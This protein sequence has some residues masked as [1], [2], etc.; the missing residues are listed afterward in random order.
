MKISLTIADPAAI[1]HLVRTLW[2]TIF[3]A[4]ITVSESADNR[5]HYTNDKYHHKKE[6]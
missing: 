3:D 5:N 4:E 1:M 6:E 2:A